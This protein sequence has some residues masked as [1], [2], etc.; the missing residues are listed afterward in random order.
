MAILCLQNN[1][2]CLSWGITSVF[3][4][5]QDTTV[6]TSRH[7]G[8]RPFFKVIRCIMNLLNNASLTMRRFS[9]QLI[10]AS[11]KNGWQVTSATKSQLRSTSCL[12]MDAPS[13]EKRYVSV[14][15]CFCE[16][17]IYD[18]VSCYCSDALTFV[19]SICIF[20][21]CCWNESLSSSM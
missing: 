4:Q 16:S 10:L 5:H 13:M 12:A 3:H 17:D 7:V 9:Q 8:T 6:A 15:C 18:V 14:L 11:G 20:R 1:M 2:N 21:M 19:V